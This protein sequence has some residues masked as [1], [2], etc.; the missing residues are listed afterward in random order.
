VFASGWEIGNLRLFDQQTSDASSF[1]HQDIRD[2]RVM[3]YFDL[4]AMQK[5][6]F[7]IP[8]TA[9]YP[10]KFYLPAPDLEAMY[11]RNIHWNGRGRWVEV[12][13]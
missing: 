10:G 3:T 2:D 1:T 13:F 11:D 12:F 6:T 9:A 5:K 4:N 8:L 7:K